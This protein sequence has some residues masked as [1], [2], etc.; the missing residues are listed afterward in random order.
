MANVLA[1]GQ[2]PE[3]ARTRARSWLFRLFVLRHEETGNFGSEAM[4]V[5][6]RHA[7][8][9]FTGVFDCVHGS[10]LHVSSCNELLRL[11]IDSLMTAAMVE[12]DYPLCTIDPRSTT[13]I[14]PG[15]GN[16]VDSLT[17][18]ESS[19]FALVS[20]EIQSTWLPRFLAFKRGGPI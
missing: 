11:P 8:L 17:N 12:N 7:L 15:S 4:L 10:V 2:T 19:E 5:F 3:E 16:I 9:C 6:G 14:G 1:A 20:Y 13:L 18:P